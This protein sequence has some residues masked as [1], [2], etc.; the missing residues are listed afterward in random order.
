LQSG[1]G[2][3]PGD[4]VHIRTLIAHVIK[5]DNS[6]AP[7]P[8]AVAEALR[9]LGWTSRQSQGVEFWAPP[10][11]GFRVHAR[12]V[13]VAPL[14][15]DPRSFELED[16]ALYMVAGPA[17]ARRKRSPKPWYGTALRDP[18]SPIARLKPLYRPGWR[19]QP[20]P[21]DPRLV[22]RFKGAPWWWG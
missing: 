3:L 17:T 5:A 9:S 21:Y 22:K 7:A 12:P 19:A 2:R 8:S 10:R 16:T 20:D 1:V 15:L 18:D 6:L 11:R 13:D 14:A 4:L